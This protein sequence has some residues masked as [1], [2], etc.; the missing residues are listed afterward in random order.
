MKNSLFKFGVLIALVLVGGALFAEKRIWSGLGDGSKWSDPRNWENGI[1]QSGDS[2]EIT[3]EVDNAV[4]VNDLGE[5][6]ISGLYFYGSKPVTFTGPKLT[7]V[8]GAAM[9][10]RN[11]S[12]INCDF[13]ITFNFSLMCGDR[14]DSNTRFPQ[15]T[16]E[17]TF[18]GNITVKDRMSF[19]VTGDSGAQFNGTLTG[20][21]AYLRNGTINFTK[22]LFHFNKPVVFKEIAHFG[23]DQSQLYFN[24]AG[25][26]YEKFIADYANYYFTVE[27]AMAPEGVISFSNVGNDPSAQWKGY[28]L[29]ANQIVN[30]FGEST[31]PGD[32]DRHYFSAEQATHHID[33]VARGT[34]NASSYVRLIG[35]MGLTWAPT[36]DFAQEFLDRAHTMTG[37]LVVSNGTI[38]MSG[39]CSFKNV[40][41]ITV[42]K[43]ATFHLASTETQSLKEVT[44]VTLE[45]GATFKVEAGSPDPF[46][47]MPLIVMGNGA[48]FDIAAGSS[49]SVGGVQFSDGT[50]SQSGE[51]S[52]SSAG[53]V[54]GEGSVNVT[55]T[56]PA[57]KSAV[58]GSFND[59]ANWNDGILPAQGLLA[60]ITANGADYTVNIAASPAANAGGLRL[61]NDGE[62]TSRLAVSK[63]ATFAGEDF[64]VGNGG[65]LEINEGGKL[66]YN[67]K[68]RGNNY[69]SLR[70]GKGG[71]IDINGGYLNVASLYG[72]FALQGEDDAEAVLSINSGTCRVYN[73]YSGGGLWIYK[74]GRLDMSG[75][76]L[77]LHLYT[78]RYRPLTLDGG[79]MDVGGNAEILLGNGFGCYF[80]N[81]TA[82]FSGNAKVTRKANDT[83]V[84][85]LIAPR[86]QNDITSIHFAE[87]SAIALAGAIGTYIGHDGPAGSKA[88][89][90]LSSSAASVAGAICSVG[91]RNGYG[92]LILENGSLQCGA[93]GLRIG[94]CVAG[95]V[96]GHDGV[97]PEGVVKVKGGQLR[98]DGTQAGLGLYDGTI[99]GDGV[100]VSNG[101]DSTS[102]YKGTLELSGG[103]VTNVGGYVFVGIGKAKGAIRQTGGLFANGADGRHVVIGSFGGEGEWTMAGGT[104]DVGRSSLY[105][106]GC[107]LADMNKTSTKDIFGIESGSKGRLAVSNG[108]FKVA[109]EAHIGKNGTGSVELGTGGVVRVASSI[110]VHDLGTL[111]FTIGPKSA[112]RLV[113]D[114][115]L[116]VDENAKLVIDVSACEN[117]P[118]R[119]KLIQAESNLGQFKPENV[120]FV[121]ATGQMRLSLEY[122]DNTLRC[123][124]GS[125]LGI[126]VR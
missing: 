102:V 23:S 42:K 68:D 10:T 61:A 82:N 85:F 103:V 51:Y 87:N 120:E 65:L 119:Y 1:P 104:T 59:A 95:N 46:A 19:Y 24:A 107:T 77:N 81:G 75:G 96:P 73:A 20:P 52:G 112:G 50:F 72:K 100:V 6:E 26:H 116:V 3:N 14:P 53:W 113:T 83:S 49:V 93:S 8:S 9:K 18:N 122:R 4:I 34:Q 109:W 11:A 16:C 38:K 115:S 48:K 70:V 15:S 57:W 64:E 123:I 67:A 71:R 55:S 88:I 89:L 2:V 92:E 27:N 25:N 56:V 114:S 33:V 54:S 32:K 22:G 39:T 91:D 84:K 7:F 121:G 30:C 28:Y 90:R 17:P 98:V 99:V 94:S 29:W 118:G 124:V 44:S 110:Y 78:T 79:T 41:K 45:D 63:T 5:M 35:D 13:H 106:G 80:G 86:T 62:H 40:S 69:R 111:K 21:G 97:C 105:V 76:V 66:V 125:G 60:Y 101:V 74:G 12:V 126:I 108:F 36:G 43:N 31:D 117:K 58:S 37:P 47:K